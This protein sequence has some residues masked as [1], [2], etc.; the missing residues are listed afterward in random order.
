MDTLTSIQAVRARSL[1]WRRDGE[2]V[3]LVPTMGNLHRGHLQLVQTAKASGTKVVVSVFVNPLQFGENEDF[4]AYPRT[5]D[6]DLRV[7]ADNHVD[8]VF[9]PASDEIYSRPNAEATRVIVPI[10]SDILCGAVRPGHF[11][12]VATVVNILLNAVQP[13]VVVFGEKDY[14]QLLVIRRMVTDLHLP[15]EVVAT[16]TVR[17]RDGLALSSRNRYLSN[18]ERAVAGGLYQTLCEARD[19]IYKNG[20]DYS[21]IER[22]SKDRLEEAGFRPDYFAIRRDSDLRVPMPGDTDLVI[23]A[24]AWLGLARLID[25]LRV[26]LKRHG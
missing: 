2:V 4:T 6:D 14:Q 5:I 23:M 18:E 19:I 25:N 21:R 15:V 20:D 11:T 3:A 7:L 10:L 24:A 9:L 26:S 12:G 22:A 13:Q 8:A 16:A 1:Q 17:D